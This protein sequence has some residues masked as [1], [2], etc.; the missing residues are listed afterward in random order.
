MK[1]TTY[2]S[3]F[4]F[5]LLFSD[6]NK[7]SRCAAYQEVGAL[8]IPD[9]NYEPTNY[10]IVQRNKKTGLVKKVGSAKKKH[11]STRTQKSK[12]YRQEK[13]LVKD[14][15]LFPDYKKNKKA[16]KRAKNAKRTDEND[17]VPNDS[18]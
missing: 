5:L 4:L 9:D 11:Y 12:I 18:L 3:L 2:I 13:R 17:V 15:E 6:C 14:N 1:L 16:S 8:G 7:R 10:I